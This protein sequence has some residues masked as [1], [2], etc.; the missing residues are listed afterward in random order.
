ME[1]LSRPPH[2]RKHSKNPYDDVFLSNGVER[3]ALEAHEYAEIFSGSS[4]I[5]VLD[6]S[7]LD[8]QVGSGDFRSSKLDYSN[9]F[10]G[11]RNDDVAVPFEELFNRSAKKTKPRNPKEGRSPPQESDS[12]HLSEKPKMPSDKV[13]DQSADGAKK[14][15]NLSFNK[16]NQRNKDPLN[17]KTH[18]AKL[19]TKEG[20]SPPQES[21]SSH[22]S[23]KLKTPSDEAPDQSADGAK[24]QFNLSFNKTNQQNTDSSN[25][26]TR[27][28]QLHTK[29]G[30]SPP[31]ESGSSHLLE[32]PK[33]PSD[34]FPDQSADGAKKQ[35]NLSFN[36]TNQQNTDPSNGK[37]HIAQLHTKEGRSPPQESD[38]S[39]LSEKPKTPSDEEPDQS[40]DGAKKQFNLSFNKTNQR[41]TDS[42]NGKTHIAQLHAVPG[43]TYFVD[44]ASRPQPA[45]ENCKTVNSLKHD[46]SRTWSFS[47][48]VKDGLSHQKLHT[49]PDKSQS[50]PPP[51]LVPKK[52]APEKDLGEGSPPYFGE[53][54]DE[55]SVAAASAAALKKAIDQAQESIRL[56]KMIMDRKKEGSQNKPRQRSSKKEKSKAKYKELEPTF[57]IFDG[58]DVKF[59]PSLIENEVFI[60]AAKI[61]V[62]RVWENISAAKEHRTNISGGDKLFSLAGSQGESVYIDE[63]IELEKTD[64]SVEAVEKTHSERA[65]LPVL[66][67]NEGKPEILETN[68]GNLDQG[69]KAF[70]HAKGP[71]V[72]FE[73]VGRALDTSQSMQ[74]L[75]KNVENVEKCRPT[76]DHAGPENKVEMVTST[77]QR[78]RRQWNVLGE[79]AKL[80]GIRGQ[81]E[82][83][84]YMGDKGKQEA[85]EML[86]VEHL[87]VLRSELESCNL[88]ENKILGLVETKR[89]SEIVS[90]RKENGCIWKT[91]DD[92]SNLWFE[93]KEQLKEAMKEE[94]NICNFPEIEEG[95]KKVDEPEVD[96]QKQNHAHDGD[97]LKLHVETE[98]N[99][100]E[101]KCVDVPECEVS[102]II[103]TGTENC[104]EVQKSAVFYDSEEINYAEEN[105]DKCQ[106][107]KHTDE[108]VDVNNSS[109]NTISS[110]SQTNDTS[111]VVSETQE[112][113]N[114]DL[115]NEPEEYQEVVQ[116]DKEN[117][118]VPEVIETF[119]AVD[120]DKEDDDEMSGIESL[121]RVA[122]E[123]IF[124]ESKL[125]NAFDNISSDENKMEYVR[126]MDVDP[127][128]ELP[129]DVS[130]TNR[131]NLPQV[132]ASDIR[133]PEFDV[134]D[135]SEQTSE[136]D[137]GS[138]STSSHENVNRLSVYEYEE[139][140][141]NTND[142]TSNSEELKD[143]IKLV[144]NE[145]PKEMEKST[146]SEKSQENSLKTVNNK[147]NPEKPDKDDYHQRIEAIKKG[148]AREKDRI[149]VERAIREARERAFAEARERAERAAVEKAAA[150]ARQRAMAEAREKL[151]KA[152]IEAKLKAERAAVERATAEARGRALEKAMSQKITLT[153][154][155]TAEKVCGS[156]KTNGL[157]HSFSSSDLENVT[158]SAQRRKARLERHQR[159]MERAAKALAEKNMRDVL[160]QKEQAERNRLAES[161]DADIKRWA[162][163]K[164]KNMRALLSTLQYILGP[165]SGW[166][167]IPLTE[168]VTTAAVKKA[169][170]KATLYVHPDKLQ[171]RGASIRQKYICEKVFDLLK[172]AWNRFN[173]DER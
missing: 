15:F 161:L 94:V 17:G 71:E 116:N 138:V 67:A 90:A 105:R 149:V 8:E 3:E 68:K 51:N 1:S 6:L 40:A 88:G 117:D 144:S 29:E 2:R 34:K 4:S 82:R 151:D 80:L 139:C 120:D 96:N 107:E 5:P 129:E 140:A 16:T 19:H 152:N 136:S 75:E 89:E 33:T 35:F 60:N 98:Q 46:V 95:K 11:F 13:P 147:E 145:E 150:E 12:S 173:S 108:A 44:G 27:I 57:T 104:A 81:E 14:Q 63:N 112:S 101:E 159:I 21:D 66:V 102:E 20:R 158:E 106:Y 30:R 54:F 165:D 47:G 100:V 162:T 157:K 49:T 73:L 50:R 153:E 141:E 115:D 137:E 122:S 61:E 69:E 72:D 143:E 78:T 128:E 45:T 53:D 42:S 62:E 74:E 167:P 97:E 9:I 132:D 164:E 134:A 58:V 83:E 127:E 91:Y 133:T 156:A 171:Q 110:E 26:K 84:D 131:Q 126:V 70:Y 135:V 125:K 77:P 43:F 130:E 18:S 39:H 76:L 154:G 92:E 93:S 111:T 85:E 41:N 56:A 109:A 37:T 121:R 23:E 123:G 86:N 38:S 65:D 48:E 118:N 7:D 79:A 160:A 142:V 59:T 25:G 124:I 148:R 31:Q 22:L 32:K 87:T 10:G 64:E 28:A 166:Q 113:S 119:S 169:Y 163:G 36:K 172:A 99:E 168:I 52:D 55:N 24:K 146:E 114:V 103:E 170:R 155:R